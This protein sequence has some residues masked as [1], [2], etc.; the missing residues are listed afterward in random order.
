MIL[1][2]LESEGDLAL[3]L[4]DRLSIETLD[5]LSASYELVREKLSVLEDAKAA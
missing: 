3:R 1:R 4:E 5:E 2:H